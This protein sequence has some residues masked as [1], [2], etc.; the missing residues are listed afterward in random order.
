MFILHTRLP[1]SSPYYSYTRL[2]PTAGLHNDIDSNFN[3]QRR[4]DMRRISHCRR[5]RDPREGDLFAA[6]M[7]QV[8]AQ[9]Q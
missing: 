8:N 9:A 5:E 6:W 3:D 1:Y 7:G 2:T 4:S